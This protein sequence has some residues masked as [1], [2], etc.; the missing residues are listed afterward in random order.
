MIKNHRIWLAVPPE[1]KDEAIKAHPRLNNGQNAIVWDP[2]QRLWYANP[3]VELNKLERWLPQPQNLSMASDDPVSEF[4]QVLENAGFVLREMPVMDGA[5]H[6]VATKADKNGVK[7]GVYK[8]YLDGRPAGWYRDYRSSEAKATNWSFSGGQDADPRTKLH[9]RAQAQQNREDSARALE[10]QY[11]RQADYA[12]R[13]VNS[14]PQATENAYLTRK[15]VKAAPGVRI[16]QNQALVVPFSN[17]MGKI[18]SYQTIPITG[19]KDARILKD[20]EKTGN[21]F[22]FG[23]PQNGKPVLFAE[24]YSTAASIHEATG[25]PVLMTV[26]AGNM[27][28][29]AE[30]A[31]AVW[32]DSPFIFCA[33][34]DHH[35]KNPLT[36]APENKG[37]LSATRA[38]E[39]T[40]GD[41]IAPAFTP[42]ELEQKLTDFNDLILSRGKD[43]AGHLINVQLHAM[44]VETPF[45]TETQTRNA[46]VEGGLVFT[47]VQETAMENQES[48]DIAQTSGNDIAHERTASERLEATA[49]EKATPAAPVLLPES[50]PSADAGR[51][52]M[53]LY[54][55]SPATFSAID[56]EKIGLGQNLVGKGFYTD[57]SVLGVHYVMEEINHKDYHV[58]EVEIPADSVVLDRRDNST[59]TDELRERIRHAGK[60]AGQQ[61]KDDGDSSRPDMANKLAD[62]EKIDDTF[63][64]FAS[65]PQGMNILKE[66][67]VTALK[68]NS[69][70]AIINTDLIDNIRLRSA[71]GNIKAEMAQYIEKALDNVAQDQSKLSDILQKEPSL[72]M[73]YDALRSELTNLAMARNQPDEAERLTAILTHAFVETVENNPDRKT[74]IT[75]L[76]R[77]YAETIR[78][79]DLNHDNTAATLGRIIDS[80]VVNVAPDQKPDAEPAAHEPAS[81]A[82]QDPIAE[83]DKPEPAAPEPELVAEP[84]NP[85]PVAPE[86]EPIAEPDNPEPAVPAPEPVAEPDNPEPVAPEPEPVAEPDKPELIPEV[87]QQETAPESANPEQPLPD[88]TPVSAST[89]AA[90]EQFHSAPPSSESEPPIVDPAPAD[91]ETDAIVYGPRRPD[92]NVPPNR[93]DIDRILKELKWETQSDNTVLYQLDGQD[94]FRD[95]GNRLEMCEG[96]SQDDRRVLA[97]LAVA[98]KFYGGVIELTGSDAFKEK[99]MRLIVDYDLDIRMKL[100]EQR[101][102]LD[103]LRKH[104]GKD[105]ALDA[106]VP[107]MPTPDLNRHTPEPPAPATA[108]E[109]VHQAESQPAPTAPSPI[110]PAATATTVEKTPPEVRAAVTNT[111]M[112]NSINLAPAVAEEPAPTPLNPGQSV[113]AVLVNHGEA[114]YENG[115]KRGGSYFIELKNRAGSHVY[116]GQDLR[117]LVQNLNKGDVVTLTLDSRDTWKK[118]G[119]DKERVKNNWSL[120]PAGTGM[121]VPHTQPEQGQRLQSFPV[122]TFGKITQ[123][124]RQSWPEYTRDLKLPPRLEARSFYLR[125]D[126]HPV[127][128]P[129][130]NATIAPPTKGEPVV[131]TPVMASM[132]PQKQQIDLLLVRSA[133]DHLQGVVRLNNTLYPAL[134]TPTADNQQLVINAVT[135]SGLRYAGY[136]QAINFEPDGTTRT[137]PQ[138]MKFQLKGQEEN[139]PVNARLYT[140]ERQDDA[141]FQ[142]LGFEQSWKQWDE[143]RKPEGRQEQNHHQDHSHAPGR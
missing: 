5:I 137:A 31:R 85:E 30:N 130:G 115:E 35:L 41:V 23:T 131:L 9:L 114:V 18:R 43:L 90:H 25:L 91:G 119:E 112:E 69:Y 127:P 110:M 52:T 66:A 94:A 8:G 134:A 100:P 34:N 50:Q 75:P 92:G 81:T 54:H 33:D 124:I 51:E 46:F 99:A 26:D 138:L 64:M 93:E 12:S 108:S 13:H 22:T 79:L 136:G 55:G 96:A 72:S 82:E 4:A 77:L 56:A 47:P 49:A 37:I 109:S 29:V 19:G 105:Q 3:G 59:L 126:R 83:P 60:T 116:W 111:P 139:A 28:A 87:S 27:I 73:H 15:G 133:G 123:Q 39:L 21:W 142:Q 98:A 132:D 122:D 2:E 104:M 71:G 97:A 120:V 16:N 78:S 129:S 125:E 24:G 63:L 7:S 20:S 117:D 44:G 80:A 118:E 68:D 70:V 89:S 106:V 53:T 14:L 84:D 62:S 11:N 103:E 140:P 143:S 76:N 17:G 38:A 107:H 86:P 32:P 57:T 65:T 6:R 67:G 101:A 121:A 141:L 1:E 128:S 10:Q 40:S 95:S 102:Q 36:G 58:Y 45:N 88:P 48:P 42:V 113:T 74:S 135:D 61:H